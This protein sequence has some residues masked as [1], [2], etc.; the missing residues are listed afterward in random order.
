MERQEGDRAIR[1]SSPERRQRLSGWREKGRVKRGWGAG[2][3]KEGEFFHHGRGE[4]EM[5]I[6]AWP[7]P[8]R[9]KDYPG[10]WRGG[11]CSLQLE[12]GFL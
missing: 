11:A 8:L 3:R 6:G 9:A 7:G 5:G 1:R 4:G 12:Q 10:L 2:E